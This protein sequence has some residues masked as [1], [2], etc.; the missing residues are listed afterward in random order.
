MNMRKDYHRGI[1]LNQKIEGTS[2][3]DV[4]SMQSELF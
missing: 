3:L 4:P 2:F 1:F